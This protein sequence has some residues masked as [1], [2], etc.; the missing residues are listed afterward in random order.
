MTWLYNNQDNFMQF[1]LFVRPCGWLRCECAAVWVTAVNA[2]CAVC[3]RVGDCGNAVCVW[4]RVSDCGKPRDA[5][6]V[7]RPLGLLALIGEQD[8]D[9][10]ALGPAQD[11]SQI[12]WPSARDQLFISQRSADHQSQISRPPGTDQLTVRPR[13]TDHHPQ[14]SGPS[15]RDQQTIDKQQAVAINQL[16]ASLNSLTPH[17]AEHFKNP[18]EVIWND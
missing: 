5:L 3:G 12:S 2:V 7:I 18:T 1:S 9:I 4:G 16:T 15:A 11:Q 8:Q 13:L 6:Q 17:A 14:I 10:P